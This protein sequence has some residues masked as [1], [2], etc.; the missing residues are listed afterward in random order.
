MQANAA[1]SSYTQVPMTMERASCAASHGL[2]S[3]TAILAHDDGESASKDAGKSVAAFVGKQMEP[4]GVD[5]TAVQQS[6][7]GIKHDCSLNADA[8]LA[9]KAVRNQ[10]IPSMFQKKRKAQLVELASQLHRV[11]KPCVEV[12]D[13]LSDD[14]SITPPASDTPSRHDFVSGHDVAEVIVI[15]GDVDGAANA[16]AGALSHSRKQC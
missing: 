2:P 6:Q 9:P 1:G 3:A 14:E 8:L 15:D 12:I 13:L 7:N 16:S 11:R 10:T 5:N 4:G